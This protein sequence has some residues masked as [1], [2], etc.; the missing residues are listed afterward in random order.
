MQIKKIIGNKIAVTILVERVI[1]LI[2]LP[3]NVIERTGISKA[4]VTV[5]GT[6]VTELIKVG[7]TVLVTSQL[8]A[9]L[10]DNTRIYLLDDVLAIL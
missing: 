10:P 6:G 2:E 4:K 5:V 7:D 1:G 9:R 8:G 3:D